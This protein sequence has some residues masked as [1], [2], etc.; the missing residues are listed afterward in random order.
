VDPVRSNKIA[1]EK[2]ASILSRQNEG[3]SKEQR[4]KRLLA[5]ERIASAVRA[6]RSKSSAS[7]STPANP[8]KSRIHA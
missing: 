6:R 1:A 8:G 4:E 7:L 2:I 3:L 5:L